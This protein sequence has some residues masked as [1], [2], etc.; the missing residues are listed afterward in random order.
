MSSNLASVRVSIATFGQ[1]S[2]DRYD[3]TPG[4]APGIA[5]H[6]HDEWQVCYS[7][8]GAGHIR[9]GRHWLEASPGRVYVVPPAMEHTAAKDVTVERHSTYFVI[10]IARTALDPSLPSVRRSTRAPLFG[11][12]ESHDAVALRSVLRLMR[13]VPRN[14]DASEAEEDALRLLEAVLPRM[15]ATP[16]DLPLAKRVQEK[17]LSSLGRCAT[18]RELAKATGAPPHR[19]RSAFKAS[20]GM[21]PARYHL[22][23][24]LARARDLIRDGVAP[25]IAAAQLGFVDQAH[26]SHRLRRY[27]GHPP[28]SIVRGGCIS[29]KTPQK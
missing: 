20:F 24:R 4:F 13:A 2:V 5:P 16:K 7:P 23:Q 18:L 9:A 22:V 14:V 27:F 11:C 26:L 28:G 21:P 1:V 25:S 12:I 15:P 8:D 3:Y 29:Y 6:A 17:L 19:V 10:Y